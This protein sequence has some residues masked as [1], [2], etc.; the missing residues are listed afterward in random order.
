MKQQN[1]VEVYTVKQLC[2][3]PDLTAYYRLDH[4]SIFDFLTVSASFTLKTVTAVYSGMSEQLQHNVA[5]HKS[6]YHTLFTIHSLHKL[7]FLICSYM[8]DNL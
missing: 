1:Y 6:Q 8:D 7:G 4:G 3:R 5:N 2:V